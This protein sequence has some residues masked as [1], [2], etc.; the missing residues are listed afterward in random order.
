MDRP[1]AGLETPKDEYQNVIG[2]NQLT[3]SI[4]IEVVITSVSI[5]YLKHIFTDVIE[6]YPIIIKPIADAAGFICGTALCILIFIIFLPRRFFQSM[7]KV[8]NFI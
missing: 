3:S 7:S 6:R 1:R 2:R 8:S 4:V 5:L